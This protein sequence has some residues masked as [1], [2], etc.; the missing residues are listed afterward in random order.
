MT[1]VGCN[2]EAYYTASRV[3]RRNAAI[4]YCA[5]RWIGQ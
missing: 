2:S 4:A 1:L 5:P 3:H